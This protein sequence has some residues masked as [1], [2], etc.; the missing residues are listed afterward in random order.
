MCRAPNVWFTAMV[1]RLRTL[2]RKTLQP[3]L[4]AIVELGVH[5]VVPL[6]AAA[7]TVTSGVAAAEARA[8][9]HLLHGDLLR[10]QVDVET[11][12]KQDLL[13]DDAS[14]V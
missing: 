2:R 3:E 8:Y 11:G 1:L 5:L 4:R 9:F 13:A 12:E 6:A 7:E 10:Y 14:L